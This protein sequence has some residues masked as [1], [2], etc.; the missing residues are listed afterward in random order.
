MQRSPMILDRSHVLLRDD[1]SDIRIKE[2]G[3]ISWQIKYKQRDGFARIRNISASGMLIETDVVFD[4]KEEC[5]FSFDSRLGADNYIP[6]VGRLVWH[7]QKRRS[8][9]QYLCGIKFLEADEQVLARMRERVSRG[10]VQFLKRRRIKMN[11]GFVLCAVC[12]SLLIFV[13]WFSGIIYRDVTRVNQKILGISGQQAALTQ[14]YARLY[15]SNEA[16]LSLAG[17]RL[18]IAGQLINENKAAIDLYVKELEATKTLLGQTETMLTRANDRNVELK[19]QLQSLQGGVSPEPNRQAQA[20][21]AKTAGIN[22]SIAEYRAQ[23]KFIKEEIT[24]LKREGYAARA[25]FIARVDNQRLLLG[26][27][28]FFT[29]DGQAVQVD[30]EKYQ[31][32]AIDN[33]LESV[34]AQPGR[35]VEIDVTFV[36]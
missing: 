15:R 20:T 35:N 12:V 36:E 18:T 33:D 32:L 6:Q 13:L 5:I 3:R 19:D 17:E 26:N 11:I 28:G 27:N 34:V 14:S 4:P 2:D 7:K 22:T 29:K 24:R 16:K 25:A 10:V 8:R 31:R 21:A 23:L 30:Q 9:N 1:R